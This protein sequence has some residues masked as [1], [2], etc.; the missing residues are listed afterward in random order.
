MKKYLRSSLC[1][2]LSILLAFSTLI[3]AFAE[4][5]DSQTTPV[6]V[7]NDI[8]ANP[9]YNTDDGSVVFD[10]RDYQY[11]LLFASGFSSEI[12]SLIST[13]TIM[14]I[15]NGK[16]TTSDISSVLL[17]SF[18]FNDDINSII[19]AV[20][21][22]ALELVGTIDLSN[23]DL[24]SILSSIDLKAYANKQLD[25]IKA[26]I[27]DAKLLAMN[28]DGTPLHSNIGI[29]SY[30]ESLEYYYSQDKNFATLL[31]GEIGLGMADE[32]GYENVY[33][34][35]YDWRLDPAANAE[36]LNSYI[37]DVKSSV[38][39]DKV[40]VISEGYGSLIATEYLA[41]YSD[42]AASNVLNFVTVSSEFL[43]TSL[44]GDYFKGAIVDEFTNI[45]TYTSAYVRYTNDL[46]DNPITA[47]V[48]W[49]LNYLMNTEW[50]AQSFCI[51]IEQMISSV[52]DL[53][54][55]SGV[56]EQFGYMPGIWALVPVA[57]YENA[58]ANMFDENTETELSSAVNAFK[59]NQKNY[60]SILNDA[61]V[62]GVNVYVVAAWDLQLLPI[63]ENSS[64]QSDG[65]VDTAYA[66]FGATCV[67]LND[68]A[69][70]MQ[71][72]QQ[73]FDGHDHM[74]ANYDM[75]T[76]W[77]SYG[78]ACYYIDASTCALP[79]NTW[80]IKN[81]KHG[82]F[83][84]NSNSIDFL[85]WLVESDAERTVWQDVAY[86]QFMNYNRYYQPGILSCN[87]LTAVEQLTEGKYLLG[88]VNL[89]GIIT[90]EDSRL[91]ERIVE[92]LEAVEEGSI[93]FMNS[94]VDGDG[95]ITSADSQLIL[96]MSTGVDPKHSIGIKVDMDTSESG[97]QASISSVELTP[98]YNAITN[99]L[100]VTVAIVNPIGTY[101]G[102]FVLDYEE[103]MLTYNS[104]V[105][106]EIDNV[107][108]SAGSPDGYGSVLTFGYSTSSAITSKQ[109]DD[110]KLVLA[111][112][113]FDVSR[114]EIKSTTLTAGS[115]YFYENGSKTYTEPVSTYLD[116][117]FFFMLGDADNNRY[118]SASDARF[119]LRVAAKLETIDD[120]L[121]FKR[122]DVDKDG[123]ITAADARLIL[124]ASAQLIDS[125]E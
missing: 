107:Y 92:G 35:T 10:W 85:V 43:G 17:D 11:D 78:G 33:V 84:S 36:N 90:A 54:N 86:S 53:L 2:L 100:E 9:I 27:E 47:F 37:S 14:G 40:S 103:D 112:Y 28:S 32:F 44:V 77:Y 122:C 102:N 7:V 81:M 95:M 26:D 115:T 20:L 66:A 52:Y 29:I 65:I 68:V 31:A 99:Q 110:G 49:L 74:S 116:E 113:I 79:E 91:A 60:S 83:D 58:V 8:D 62:S 19:N 15:I 41:E 108:V 50:E 76:P 73:I 3:I 106:E 87:G 23:L 121:T 124:R 104:V 70:A 38:G 45:T 22:V 93:P 98:V 61:K 18:G 42:S 80:F 6:V 48:I 111:T 46:S 56:T 125:F 97:M 34:F 117:E 30:N 39:A 59:E 13:E 89:D 96:D 114:T 109:C 25:A 118:I 94:D 120:D 4:E 123:K 82:T 12:S 1:C 51:D 67:E 63:G 71:A 119:V 64:V 57:D 16:L 101:A 75:L 5:G 72:Q 21:E 55:A 24:N 69:Y 88:D 105:I